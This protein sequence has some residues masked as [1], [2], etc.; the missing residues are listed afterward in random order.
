MIEDDLSDLLRVNLQDMIKHMMTSEVIN[1]VSF[2]RNIQTNQTRT[3]SIL[4]LSF[5]SSR[6]LR[7]TLTELRDRLLQ[8]Q[9]QIHILLVLIHSEMIHLL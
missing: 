4:L 6:Q 7:T 1:L 8:I 3:H 5:Q 9:A 2:S